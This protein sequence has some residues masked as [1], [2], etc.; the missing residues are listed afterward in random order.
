M[1]YPIQRGFTLIELVV[2]IIILGVL[3]VVAAP[4]FIDIKSDAVKA[5]LSSLQGSIQS[6]NSLVYSKAVIG[7]QETLDPGEIDHNGIKISTTLGYITATNVNLPKAIEGSFAQMAGAT[8]EFSEDWGIYNIPNSGVY[9]FPQ[10]Y[11]ISSNC[12]L[13]YLVDGNN[14]EPAFYQ[15]TDTGC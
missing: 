10:G 14:S 15:I 6:A 9:I 1:K 5:N 13:H 11:D 3:A 12:S 8:D 2:V 4:K 7:S